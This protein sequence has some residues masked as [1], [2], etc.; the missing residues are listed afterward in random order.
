MQ[1]AEIERRN[2]Q[3]RIVLKNRADPVIS[4]SQVLIKTRY[5]GL[6]FK[7]VKQMEGA[8]TASS[9]ADGLPGIEFSGTVVDAGPD[10]TRSVG[11]RVVGRIAGGAI[12]D[13]V[14]VQSRDIVPLG[15]EANDKLLLAGA[16]SFVAVGTASILL[17][18]MAR[19]REGES[20]LVHS[21]AGGVGSALGLL[22]RQLGMAP[23]IGVVGSEE[24]FAGAHAVGYD[25]VMVRQRYSSQVREIV[26]S[27]GLDVIADP[28]GG[29]IRR[30]AFDLLAPLGRLLAYGRT[31]TSDEGDLDGFE[32]RRRS[33]AFMGMTNGQLL[34]AAPALMRRVAERS[35]ERII[36]GLQVP[37]ACIVPFDSVGEGFFLL[38]TGATVGKV[39]V[40]LPS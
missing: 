38:A 25:H 20:L 11:E 3:Q 30:E 19:V 27:A 24:K 2:A 37:V 12:A 13:L 6:N 31:G 5:V 39:V 21:A 40:A 26:G 16:A 23:R 28:L 9:S 15:R 29:S 1:R 35:V 17:E 32:Y 33:V 34:D 4:G 8:S 10:A 18:E 22:A 36:A 7:D 14:A